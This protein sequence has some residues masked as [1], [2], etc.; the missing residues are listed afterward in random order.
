MKRILSLIVIM[1]L[2]GGVVAAQMPTLF[3]GE[4]SWY[5]DRFHGRKT[6]NGETYDMQQMTAA[7]RTLPFGT[8]VRVTNLE[9]D[10]SVVVR[11][12]DR[13]PFIAGRILDVSRAAAEALGMVKSGVARVEVRV[14]DGSAANT[15]EVAQ[16]DPAKAEIDG[17]PAGLERTQPLPVREEPARPEISRD[18]QP[19]SGSWAVQVGAFRSRE[20]A[21][22]LVRSLRARGQDAWDNGDGS[23]FR[24]Y[25]GRYASRNEA[26]EM[27][28][29]TSIEF[30]GA[31]LKQ[32]P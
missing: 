17:R 22:G 11:I 1:I 4:A 13:G 20:A 32:V 29:R 21:S 26:L 15:P 16:P 14:V 31:F 19:A 5:G 6:A 9:N 10:R 7:H 8:L 28:G 23:F 3:Y 12:N 18:V 24:V 25:V 27:L 2:V 30:P